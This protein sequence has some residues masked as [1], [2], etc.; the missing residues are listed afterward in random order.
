MVL[1]L[2]GDDDDDGG[3]SYKTFNLYISFSFFIVFLK[4]IIGFLFRLI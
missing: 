4:Y 3:K 2:C 1:Y